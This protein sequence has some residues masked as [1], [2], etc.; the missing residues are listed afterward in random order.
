[1]AGAVVE[2]LPLKPLGLPGARHR[3]L[4]RRLAAHGVRGGAAYDGLVAATA[5]HHRLTLLTRDRRA[6]VTY[7]AVGVHYEVV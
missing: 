1:V 3:P 2:A 6:R 4:I 7:D 5:L